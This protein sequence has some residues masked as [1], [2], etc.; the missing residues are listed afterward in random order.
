ME[1]SGSK[2]VGM[3]LKGKLSED[4]QPQIRLGSG[5]LNAAREVKYLGVLWTKGMEVAKHIERAR[6][7][8]GIK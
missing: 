5:K 2:T 7:R 6:K 4:R 1:L 8:H 3:L